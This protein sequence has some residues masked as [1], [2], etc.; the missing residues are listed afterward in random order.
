[1]LKLPYSVSDFDSLVREGYHYVDR[2][3]YIEQLEELVDKY[4]FF[5]RPRRFGKSLFISILHHYYGLEY[6]ADFDELFRGYY[7]EYILSASE[8]NTVLIRLFKRIKQHQS[9]A[10]PAF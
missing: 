4:I 8:P 3:S 2:T 5:L 1:M 6:A 10:T 9:G 7:R